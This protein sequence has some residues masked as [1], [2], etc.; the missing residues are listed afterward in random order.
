MLPNVECEDGFAFDPGDGLAHER[1]VL[2]RGRTD[3]EFLVGRDVEPS[4]AGAKTGRTGLG[5]V[6]L[7]LGETAELGLDGGR[8]S[9]RRGSAFTGAHNGPEEGVVAVAAGVVAHAPANGLG[10]F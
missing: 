6:F 5:E 3:G 7:E 2:V 4:P 1:A 10:N 9:A 8:Q